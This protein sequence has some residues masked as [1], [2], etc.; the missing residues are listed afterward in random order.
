[1]DI[2]EDYKKDSLKTEELKAEIE[3]L[4]QVIEK[5]A[6]D[7]TISLGEVWFIDTTVFEYLSVN[8]PKLGLVCLC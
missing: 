6:K 8:Q 4:K 5:G 3:K 2:N 7:T 1:M